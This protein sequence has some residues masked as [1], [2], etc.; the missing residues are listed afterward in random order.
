MLIIIEKYEKVEKKD[1]HYP[2]LETS[3]PASYPVKTSNWIKYI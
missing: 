2:I 1:K 3:L